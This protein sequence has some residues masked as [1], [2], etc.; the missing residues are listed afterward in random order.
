MFR[1]NQLSDFNNSFHNIGFVCH[2][3]IRGV[4]EV[5]E[6][7]QI[8]NNTLY[9]CLSGMGP[10]L[11]GCMESNRQ[12]FDQCTFQSTDIVWQLKAQVGFV[13]YI[14]LKNAIHRRRGE[15]N[16]VGTKI[17]SAGTAEFT[18]AAG[19]ARFQSHAV[20]NLQMGHA[21]AHLDDHTARFMAKHKGRFHH[22]ITDGTRITT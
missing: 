19:L 15:E 6:L 10:T 4:L 8:G 2:T 5:I 16:Y 17:I 13:G 9:I 20:T 12:W 11:I 21:L 18:V 22:I 1:F 14:L 7:K 3:A